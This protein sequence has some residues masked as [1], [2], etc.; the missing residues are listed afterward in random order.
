MRFSNA[1]K[2]LTPLLAVLMLL[3]APAYSATV[4]LTVSTDKPSYI[5]GET[6]RITGTVKEDT[7]PKANVLVNVEVRDPSG[8]L[9]F[10]DVVKT[11]SDG[12][13]STSFR[14]AETLPTGTYTVKAVYGGVSKT[15]TFTLS[16]A[17][18]FT[19]A[20][21]P[22]AVAV[23]QGLYGSVNVR[24]QAVAGYGYS[25][26]LSAVAPRGLSVAFTQAA[27]VPDFE[28]I[29][30]VMASLDTAKGSYTV[31]VKA[32]GADGTEVSKNLTVVV[33]EAP[34]AVAELNETVSK[35]ESDLA[36]IKAELS[37]LRLD[38]AALKDATAGLTT[39]LLR[40]ET[41][42]ETLSNNVSSL[43]NSLSSLQNSVSSLSSSLSSL[44]DTVKSIQGSLGGVSG[45]AYGA[46]ALSIIALIVAVYALMTLR[47]KLAS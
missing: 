41:A 7:T 42:L 11:A 22:E 35:L 45:A 17:P 8:T 29:A 33:V 13:F 25:V 37:S 14:L 34:P 44:S 20:L 27:G 47:R 16:A 21:S 36:S 32:K 4:T 31:T 2:L 30:V 26:A 40:V 10:A 18:T 28:S 6:V 15:A 3:A 46:I 38:V 19:V 5:L 39:R 24:L 9:R 43:Q 12:S 1:L 23:P